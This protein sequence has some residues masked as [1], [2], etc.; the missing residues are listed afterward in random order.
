MNT[1]SDEHLI[2]TGRGLD[3]CLFTRGMT[4]SNEDSVSPFISA[5]GINL[6]LGSKLESSGLER[7]HDTPGEN[8]FSLTTIR[9]SADNGRRRISTSLLRRRSRPNGGRLI[10]LAC[11]APMSNANKIADTH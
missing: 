2:A 3:L 7:S 5:R 8:S 10:P 6:Y 1:R 9:V 4:G 11:I